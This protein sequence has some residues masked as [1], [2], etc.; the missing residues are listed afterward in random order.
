MNDINKMPPKCQYCPYW[1]VCKYPWVCPDIGDNKP[2]LQPTC[3]KLATDAI[4]RY[5]VSTW[6]ANLGY[7]RLA[8]AIMDEDRFPPAQPETHDKRTETHACDLPS[9]QPEDIQKIQ[10]LEQAQFDKMY[11]LGYQAGR[12]AQPERKRGKWE[13]DLKR[14]VFV[15]SICGAWQVFNCNYCSNCGTDMRE[16]DE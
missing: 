15:C 2:D 5:G 4:S 13:M 11:E 12:A 1:E 6:L 10:D 16:V 9:A 7:P 3:N 8:D 14:H